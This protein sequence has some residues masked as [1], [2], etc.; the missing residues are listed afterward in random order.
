M[1]KIK[2]PDELKRYDGGDA[3]VV[4]GQEESSDQTATG[5]TTDTEAG[6]AEE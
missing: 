1:R 4:N 5:G 6:A 3:P 2:F